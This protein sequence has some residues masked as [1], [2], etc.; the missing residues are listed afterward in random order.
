MLAR[1]MI[2]ELTTT[3]H[4][5]VR[6]ALRISPMI[7]RQNRITSDTMLLRLG[8]HPLHYYVDLK[9]LGFAEHIERLE[10]MRL[11][12]LMRDSALPGSR[13]RGGQN[14]IHL[15]FVHQSL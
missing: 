3:Y 10:P 1:A 4:R 2:Y 6:S 9:T 8:L 12:K 11:P 14:K 5:M 13:K 15:K 7:Q